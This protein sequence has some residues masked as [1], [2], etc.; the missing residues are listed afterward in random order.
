[1]APGSP[2]A[3]KIQSTWSSLPDASFQYK[4]AAGQ[5]G[6]GVR[7]VAVRRPLRC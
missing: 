3:D 7:I 6:H 2:S 4:K 1:N 5:G